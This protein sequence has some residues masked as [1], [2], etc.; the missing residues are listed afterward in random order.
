MEDANLPVVPQEGE[1]E[2]G[3]RRPQPEQQIQQERKPCQLQAPAQ[4]TH[5]I[6]DKA[7]R[8]P[9]QE[10]QAKDRRLTR[11]VYV[12]GQRSRREKNPPRPLPS[13]S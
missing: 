5:S 11:D 9:Q 3:R 10:A 7:Q 12:H 1:G 6:V 4:G 13:S 8:R 2:Q